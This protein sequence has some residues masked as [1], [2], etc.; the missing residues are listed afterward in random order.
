MNEK[1]ED[2][3]WA[4]PKVGGTGR[5]S[6]NLPDGEG[7]TEPPLVTPR[8]TSSDVT[9][10]GPDG[11]T[12][13]APVRMAVRAALHSRLASWFGDDRQAFLV[14]HLAPVVERIVADRLAE[15]EF[16]IEQLAEARD[17]AEARNERVEDDLWEAAKEACDQ[18][19]TTRAEVMRQ[20][21]RDAITASRGAPDI[22][23]KTP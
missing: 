18:L 19:G 8:Y 4:Y 5:G 22:G 6:S 7:V 13:L 20:A 15:A 11:F 2:R 17:R 10:V 3:P 16:H 14:S 21:L 12:R 23:R 1:D 9:L